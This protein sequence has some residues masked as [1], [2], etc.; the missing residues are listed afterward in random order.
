M[1]HMILTSRDDFGPAEGLFDW[2]ATVEKRSVHVALVLIIIAVALIAFGV[3]QRSGAHRQAW[4]AA[5]RAYFEAI[6]HRLAQGQE[7]YA[8]V[9]LAWDMRMT[10]AQFEKHFGYVDL[11]RQ[12]ELPVPDP[13]ITHV[14]THRLSRRVFYLRFE[15]NALV[16]VVSYFGPDEFMADLPTVHE[17][18]A[19]ML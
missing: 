13:D 2:E 19:Q 3:G 5:S 16:H 14:Y 1:V 4:Q 7:A 9:K 6:G 15:D 12:Q 18:M 17:R 10:L 8:R 11:V